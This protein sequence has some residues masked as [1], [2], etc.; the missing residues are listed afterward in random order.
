M[1]EIKEMK[2]TEYRCLLKEKIQKT[3]LEYLKQKRK[4]KGTE[5]SYETLH[6]ADYLLPNSSGLKIGEKQEIFAIRN[7]MTNIPA[8][9][10]SKMGTNKC[11]CGHTEQ[12]AHIY[13]CKYLNNNKI[14]IN[15]ENIYRDNV[16]NVKIVFKRFRRNMQNREKILIK[17]RKSHE[18]F[19][20][21]LFSVQCIV[22]SIG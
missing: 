19:T 13:E 4:N 21:P 1:K 7:R 8:N 18:T 10:K 22:D 17:K 20:G 9:F 3:A 11:V 6:M 15:Y 14:T 5:I 2:E 12:M 16:E